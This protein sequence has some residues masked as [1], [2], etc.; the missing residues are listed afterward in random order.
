M[1]MNLMIHQNVEKMNNFNL[2]IEKKL[3][4]NILKLLQKFNLDCF[5][6]QSIIYFYYYYY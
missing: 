6:Y 3:I 1:V 5:T 4:Y 2:K